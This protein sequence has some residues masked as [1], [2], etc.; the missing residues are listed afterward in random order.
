MCTSTLPGKTGNATVSIT[1]GAYGIFPNPLIGP[2]EKS[3]GA[4]E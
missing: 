3:P 2:V 4:P 1:Q